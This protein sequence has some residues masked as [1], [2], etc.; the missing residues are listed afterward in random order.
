VK[1]MYQELKP[2]WLLTGA[3][4]LFLLVLAVVGDAEIRQMAIGK[5]VFFAGG[6]TFVGVMFWWLERGPAR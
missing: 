4:V 6:L 1:E 2:L 3:A 5:L